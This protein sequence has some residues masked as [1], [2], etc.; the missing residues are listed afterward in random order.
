MSEILTKLV[1]DAS[2]GIETIIELTPQE[3]AEHNEQ[4][5]AAVAFRE[6]QE[7]E[8]SARLQLKES[9]E[10]KLAALGLTA[11]EIAAL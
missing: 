2:T 10:A 11:E 1:I 5:A 9:A 8:K 3:I 4:T 7:A 6:A